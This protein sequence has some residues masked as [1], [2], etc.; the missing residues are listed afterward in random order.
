MKRPLVY[1]SITTPDGELLDRFAVTHWRAE[2]D[3]AVDDFENIGSHAANSLLAQ[4]IERY[5]AE[6]QKGGTR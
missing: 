2:I 4:R 1:V 3:D 5:L 6:P